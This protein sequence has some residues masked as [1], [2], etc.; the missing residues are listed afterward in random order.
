MKTIFVFCLC[1]TS[2]NVLSDHH[3]QRST[4]LLANFE[5]AD[6]D[7]NKGLSNE[8]FTVFVMANAEAEIGRFAMIQKRGMQD[9]IFSR[10]DGNGDGEVT[11]PELQAARR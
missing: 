1:L 10:M 6:R 5:A 11:L 8:E 9:L 2:T 7:N 3:E 4:L